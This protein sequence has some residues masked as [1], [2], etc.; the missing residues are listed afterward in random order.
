MAILIEVTEK[1][2]ASLKYLDKTQERYC[3]NILEWLARPYSLLVKVVILY[4][5]YCV[6]SIYSIGKL[7]L[8]DG[9]ICILLRWM[10][11]MIKT[12][13]VVDFV[14]VTFSVAASKIRWGDY[15]ATCICLSPYPAIPGALC[16]GLPFYK[17]M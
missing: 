12:L 3:V 9:V 4:L 1:N 5:C 16:T 2:A 6:R 11:R 13:W 10:E 14:S 8:L 17:S 15:C 7:K